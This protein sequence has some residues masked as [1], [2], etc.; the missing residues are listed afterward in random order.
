MKG[1]AR[2]LLEEG[3]FSRGED[4][5]D[6]NGPQ[7]KL[8]LWGFYPIAYKLNEHSSTTLHVKKNLLR[9]WMGAHFI[10]QDVS[11][12]PKYFERFSLWVIDGDET[13]LG[14]GCVFVCVSCV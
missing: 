7:R 13:L 14:G 11:N 10:V 3:V 9:E 6:R 4:V 5:Y 8:L 1:I 2:Q 12:F